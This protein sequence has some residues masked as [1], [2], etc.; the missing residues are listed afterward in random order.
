MDVAKN[1]FHTFLISPQQIK[2]PIYQRK[3]SWE[4]KQWEQLFKDIEKVGSTN[5]RAHFIGS[6]VHTSKSLTISNIIVID[7]Q[8]RITTLSLLIAALANCLV[9]TPKYQDLIDY[10]PQDIVEEY[11]FNAHRKGELRYKLVLTK[12]DDKVYRNI[13]N[14]ILPNDKI[15][16]SDDDKNHQIYKAYEYF[17]NKIN[18][19]NIK[20]IWDGI[21]K[22]QIII[23]NLEE[24][25]DDSPHEIFESLNAKGLKLTDADLIRNFILMDSGEEEQQMIYTEYWHPMESVFKK[26]SEFEDFIKNYL[27]VKRDNWVSNEVYEE[28]KKFKDDQEILDIMEDM[29]KYWRIY[30]KIVFYEEKNPN[31]KQSFKSIDQLPYNII[32]PF[33]MNLYV[34]YENGDL[35]PQDY[36][37]IIEYTESFLLRRNICDRDSQSIKGFFDRMYKILSDETSSPKEYLEH[38]KSILSSRI[39]K[40]SMPDDEEFE[41]NFINIDL[42]NKTNKLSKYVLIKLTNYKTKDDIEFS[43]RATIEH[44]MPQNQ[45]L[46]DEWKKELMSDGSNW[47]ETYR[48]YLHVVGNL[49]LTSSNSELGDR[50]FM[51]KRTMDGGYDKSNYNI[52]K[53]FKDNDITRWNKEEINK[54]G[55]HLFEIAKEIWK[56]P[57]VHETKED[58]GEVTLDTFTKPNVRYWT[59]CKEQ[60]KDSIFNTNQT[61][62]DQSYFYLPINS[63]SAN[64]YLR[65]HSINKEVKTQLIIYDKALYEYLENQKPNIKSELNVELEWENLETRKSSTI[66]VTT[67]EFDLDDDLEWKKS[68]AWQIDKA[69]KFYDVFH[70]RIQ[71]FKK[72]EESEK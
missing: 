34:D 32:R 14:N 71:E 19:R 53:Y 65:I 18:E 21:K 2:I 16:L 63:K 62:K 42:Y 69:E 64:I 46:S 26:S 66:T 37:E 36:I 48:N 45:N 38:F 50:P 40:T 70:D 61:P 35:S 7:G 39:G 22:L 43:S 25:K 31:L 3:Y 67:N 68:I 57:E 1:M 5:K 54:R 27:T 15:L 55:K 20:S 17:N 49:T 10:D 41:N 29:H 52:N 44:I 28:F 72:I 12:D 56:L 8:Q 4:K 6:L 59:M 47:E 60:L 9:I 51:E 58:E 30:K 33:L 13:L 23:I 11:L 24:G